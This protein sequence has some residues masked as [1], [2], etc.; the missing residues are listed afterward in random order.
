MAVVGLESYSEKSTIV[1]RKDSAGRAQY[2]AATSSPS[3]AHTFR[4]KAGTGSQG[5]GAMF[6]TVFLSGLR[7]VRFKRH[8]PGNVLW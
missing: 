2:C 1:Y 8:Q 3:L 5:G 6:F 4:A 7:K